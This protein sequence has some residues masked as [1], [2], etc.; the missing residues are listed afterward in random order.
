MNK[1][2]KYLH[3][4]EGFWYIRYKDPISEKWKSV[5][6]KLPSTKSNLEKAIAYRDKLLSE[7]TK[8]KVKQIRLGDIQ[9][10]YDH[11]LELNANK[12]G[13]TINTY[14]LF[15]NYFTQKFSPEL[16]C[17]SITKQTAESFLLWLAKQN[18]LMQN[19]KFSIQKNF[20]KF[21]GFLFEYEYIPTV[22]II[23]KNVKTRPQ[24]KEPK[25]FST[26]DREKILKGLETEGKNSNFSTMVYMLM[27]TGLRPSDII[28]I[29]VEQIDL[30]KMEMRFYSSKTDNWFVRPIHE[31][32]K[33]ILTTR[34]NEVKTGRIFNYADVKTMARAVRRYYAALKMTD[35]GYTVRTFRKDF[36]SRSQESGVSIAATAMLVGHSNIKTTMTYY[37]K[38]SSNHLK[39]ELSKLK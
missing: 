33:D 10:A 14:S 18:N 31:K 8:I 26:E 6:T 9:A 20:V 2:L 37:T 32:L 5:S 4:K 35:K 7:I 27:Y 16:P 17:T 36:I 22:F 11:F 21:L 1:K 3:E 38:F 24:V 34:I 13:T 12:A 28:N 19:T 30:S 29:T 25:V 15:F 39:D 23:N